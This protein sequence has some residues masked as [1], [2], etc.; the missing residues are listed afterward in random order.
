M[1]IA[2]LA[3]VCMIFQDCLGVLMVQ[4]EARNHGWLAGLCDSV[5]WLFAI[6][7]TAITVTALQGH[8]LHEKVLVII[9]V[10]MANLV[11]SQLGVLVGRRWIKEGV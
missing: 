2:V 10:T 9:L 5:Q 3:A 1:E 6:A 4:S 7:T 11:G 8:S